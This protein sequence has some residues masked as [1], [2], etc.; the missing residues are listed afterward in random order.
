MK[1]C[2]KF[3]LDESE[4]IK[5]Q[6]IPTLIFDGTLQD[7]FL[8]N[9]DRNMPKVL[10]KPHYHNSHLK[11]GVCKWEKSNYCYIE[12]WAMIDIIKSSS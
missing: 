5:F 11:M 6:K 10:C 7:F 1:L 12:V 4:N 3:N 9:D 2:L 8:E